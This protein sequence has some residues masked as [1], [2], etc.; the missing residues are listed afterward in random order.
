MSVTRVFLFSYTAIAPPLCIADIIDVT[1][2]VPSASRASDPGVVGVVIGG[3]YVVLYAA[4]VNVDVHNHTGTALLYPPDARLILSVADRIVFPASALV[5]P[6]NHTSPALN[7][8]LPFFP[9]Y[10]PC[11]MAELVSSLL[12]LQPR[13]YVTCL[14]GV[15]V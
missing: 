15:N 6:E 1:S 2:Y 11:T 8:S 10:D 14:L 9:R 13:R 3:S 12:R 4:S 5:A 7:R